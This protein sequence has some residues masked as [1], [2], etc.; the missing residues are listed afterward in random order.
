[1]PCWP[2]PPS[3]LA[4]KVAIR[5]SPLSPSQPI[6]LQS[7]AATLYYL[8]ASSV[9]MIG[10]SY[11]EKRFGRGF[12]TAVSPDKAETAAALGVGASK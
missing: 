2:T 9:L 4:S 10:Q 1:M 11:L 5:Q 8:I 7:I 12:G 3:S 6:I